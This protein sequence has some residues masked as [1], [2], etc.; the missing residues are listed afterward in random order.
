M[1]TMSDYTSFLARC[2][3]L[4]VLWLQSDRRMIVEWSQGGASIVELIIHFITAATHQAKQQ[5]SIL[6]TEFDI[7]SYFLPSTARFLPSGVEFWILC[8]NVFYPAPPDCFLQG[9]ILDSLSECFLPCTAWFLPSG[10]NFDVS[11]RIMTISYCINR[12]EIVIKNFLSYN[13]NCSKECTLAHSR[14]QRGCVSNNLVTRECASCRRLFWSQW[15]RWANGDGENGSFSVPMAHNK[16]IP[17]G[18][19]R[20]THS[21]NPTPTF[22]YR[23]AK[24]HFYA[25]VGASH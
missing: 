15:G 9:W 7:L 21:R 6:L 22:A 8:L 18:L 25:H 2:I 20:A 10:L 4:D 13:S 1:Y 5:N 24:R 17:N 3:G 16:V 14:N 12:I 19:L 23:V 11:V